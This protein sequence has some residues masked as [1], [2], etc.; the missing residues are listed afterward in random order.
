MSNKDHL[1]QVIKPQGFVATRFGFDSQMSTDTEHALSK[2]LGVD[3]PA[4]AV[5]AVP[6][7]GAGIRHA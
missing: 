3:V 4:V 7:T 2:A 1:L 5:E 6:D